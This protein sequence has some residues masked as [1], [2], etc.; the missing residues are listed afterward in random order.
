MKDSNL[1]T[2]SWWSTDLLFSTALPS[3]QPTVLS[4]GSFYRRRVGGSTRLWTWGTKPRHKPSLIICQRQLKSQHSCF[5]ESSFLRLYYP[6][7]I[8]VCMKK[9][10]RWNDEMF[11]STRAANQA[12]KRHFL[13]RWKRRDEREMIGLQDAGACRDSV[14]TGF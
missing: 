5:K 11:P 12:L 13:T 10:S 7:K 4:H 2:T 8:L 9:V 14:P 3:H 1:L 6:N